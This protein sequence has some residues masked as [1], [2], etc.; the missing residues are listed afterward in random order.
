MQVTLLFICGF[1]FVAKQFDLKPKINKCDIGL[2]YTTFTI[3]VII[4]VYDKNFKV[5]NFYVSLL[6]VICIRH[7]LFYP[8]LQDYFLKVDYLR[9][10]HKYILER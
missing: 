10:D 6:C 8:E 3:L 5:I 2:S 7:I 1:N 4:Q 9:I